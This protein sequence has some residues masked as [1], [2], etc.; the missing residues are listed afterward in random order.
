MLD[1]IGRGVRG[2]LQLRLRLGGLRELARTIG[3]RIVGDVS[4]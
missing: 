4:A 2:G 1:L 3:N